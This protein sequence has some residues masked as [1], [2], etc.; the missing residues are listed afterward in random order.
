MI[1]AVRAAPACRWAR[2]P[3]LARLDLLAATIANA[4][5]PGHRPSAS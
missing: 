5:L 1:A 2:D 3:L 4:T